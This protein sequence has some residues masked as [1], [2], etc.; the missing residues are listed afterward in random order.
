MVYCI[1]ASLIFSTTARRN[2]VRNALETRI[3][4]RERWSADTITSLTRDGKA[5]LQVEL[6]F[7]SRA[8]QEDLEARMDA[9]FPS[10]PPL[11]GSSLVLHDCSHDDAGGC[12]VT[13]ERTW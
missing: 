5:A 6:R 8:D 9:L 7:V 13:A 11:A 4:G 3:Q 12:T 10:N 2:N 1:Q